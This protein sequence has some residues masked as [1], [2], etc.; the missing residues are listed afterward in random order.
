MPDTTLLYLL[1]RPELIQIQD[2]MWDT[3]TISIASHAIAPVNNPQ[4]SWVFTGSNTL[5]VGASS[6]RLFSGTGSTSAFALTSVGVNANHCAINI[7][8]NNGGDGGI[9]FRAAD[10]NNHWSA[11]VSHDVNTGTGD[12]V[13][14]REVIGGSAF[15]R[16]TASIPGGFIAQRPYR[17]R[18]YDD[19]R[20]I[21]VF[22]D[23]TLMF[24]YISSVTY[25]SKVG[26]FKGIINV[27]GG[28]AVNFS[29][30]LASLL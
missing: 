1:A 20:I 14:L 7:A 22:L 3:S 21:A 17:L 9:L 24:T 8:I 18:V 28:S 5:T 27:N 12:Q 10:A 6:Y 26:I 15:Q 11:R 19:G 23:E 2:A 4:A 29:G 13:E 16:A 25:G 30:F